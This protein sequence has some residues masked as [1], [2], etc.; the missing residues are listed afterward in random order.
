M[1]DQSRATAAILELLAKR[2]PGATICPSEVARLVWP[3][4]WRPRMEDVRSAART[5]VAQGRLEVTQRGEVVEP[6]TARGPIRLRLPA[7][8]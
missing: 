5:L 3:E 7:R 4:D 1:G 6:A 8:R 2:R